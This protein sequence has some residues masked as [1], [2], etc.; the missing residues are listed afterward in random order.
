MNLNYDGR[1]ITAARI[2]LAM[3]HR[4]T[5]MMPVQAKLAITCTKMSV[6]MNIQ[7]TSQLLP[8]HNEWPKIARE[9]P[10][11][12]FLGKFQDLSYGL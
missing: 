3:N 12:G 8:F 9:I 7:D 4:V 2:S 6:S 10:I 1:C 5:I 11:I